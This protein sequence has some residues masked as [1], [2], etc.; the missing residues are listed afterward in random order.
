MPEVADYIAARFDQNCGASTLAATASA[1]AFGH[2]SRGLPD[3]TA[4]FRIRHLLA[5][6]RRLRPRSDTRPALSL[7]EL[8]RLCAAA[9]L[10]S[11]SP[12]EQAAYRAAFA[13]GFFGMF[14][15][16]ELTTGGDPSHVIRLEDVRISGDDMSVTV[17]SSKTAVTPHLARLSARPDLP[18]CPVAAMRH[19]LSIR[20]PGPPRQLF[21]DASRRPMSSRHL[22]RALQRAGQRAG[23]P[24]ARLTAH[25]LR[26]SGA[27]HGATV[28]LTETQL[29]TA[30]RWTSSA[31]WGYLRR[32]V[33]LLAA[34]PAPR[35]H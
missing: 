18:S 33:S 6:A 9:P 21:I 11:S 8:D 19:Y 13:L 10:T 17:P 20:G 31:V 32:P 34:T 14:R 3:P 16:G 29:R 12:V 28:G 7:A 5:G 30:G 22:N 24:A 15:P 25:C 2:K 1:I 4:D 23:L 35:H 26:I 27:S